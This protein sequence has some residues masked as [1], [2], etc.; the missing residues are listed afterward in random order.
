MG[1]PLVRRFG[2][3]YPT[4]SIGRQKEV[5]TSY[6]RRFSELKYVPIFASPACTPGIHD[7]TTPEQCHCSSLVFLKMWNIVIERGKTLVDAVAK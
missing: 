7:L 5:F 2:C 3:D 1:H 6:W 4:L